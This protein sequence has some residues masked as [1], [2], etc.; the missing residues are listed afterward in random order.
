[1]CE[2][3]THLLTNYH[4]TRGERKGGEVMDQV[5]FPRRLSFKIAVLKA[6]KLGKTKNTLKSKNNHMTSNPQLER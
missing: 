2:E 4:G 1:M 6:E 5:L 3:Y